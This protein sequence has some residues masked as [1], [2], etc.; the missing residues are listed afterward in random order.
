MSEQK[1]P[2]TY[3]D[4]KIVYKNPWIT[5]VEDKVII[6]NGT[7]GIYAYLDF[8]DGACVLPVDEDKNVYLI[9]QYRYAMKKYGYEAAGG[10]GKKGEAHLDIAQRELKEELG[11][12]AKKW[13]YAGAIEPLNAYARLSMHMYIVQDL[14]LGKTEHEENERI[15]VIKM[16]LDEAVKLVMNNEITDSLV[17]PL[18]LK[19]KLLLG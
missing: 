8:A 10:G 18:I 14:T 4:G 2:W 17:V 16:P 7:E 11:I 12:T 1:P 19:A 15:E 9:K 5:L 3:I 13:T 6:P